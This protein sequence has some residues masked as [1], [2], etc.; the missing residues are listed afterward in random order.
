M[1]A[2]EI[3]CIPSSFC[4]CLLAPLVYSLYALSRPSYG[5]FSL[6]IYIYVCMYHFSVRLLIKKKKKKVSV[7]YMSNT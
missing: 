6:Y 5:L 3:F 1:R 4:S 2:G 7:V